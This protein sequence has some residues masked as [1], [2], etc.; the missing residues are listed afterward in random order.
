MPGVFKCLL[1]GKS[2][3]EPGVIEWPN[4]FLPFKLGS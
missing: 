4:E 3:E 2:L 1:G